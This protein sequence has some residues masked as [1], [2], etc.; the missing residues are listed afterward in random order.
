MQAQ[1]HAF[2]SV[3][4]I[5]LKY[6]F[7]LIYLL[8][9][10]LPI[11]IINLF[12]YQRNAESIRLREEIN[13]RKSLERASAELIGMIDEGVALS[14]AL[15]NDDSLYEAL[16]R[17]YASPVDYYAEYDSF[18][19]TKLD[20]FLSANPNILEIRIYTDNDTMI[21]G[22]N[23]NVIGSGSS[24]LPWLEQ[25]RQSD[26]NF[27]L[28]AYEGTG[29][30]RPGQRISV[31]SKMRTFASYRKYERY[32]CIDLNV[33]KI[34]AVLNRETESVQLG[35]LDNGNRIVAASA[36]MNRQGAQV[37]ITPASYAG[38]NGYVME[39]AIG[40]NHYVQGWK[41][42]GVA[43]TQRIAGLLDSARRSILW[44]AGLCTVIPT[45]LIFIILRSY[46]YRVKKLSRHMKKVRYE[47]FD[48]LNIPEGRD[49]VGDLIRTF[50][51]MTAKIASLINDVYKLEIRQKSLELERVRAELSMLHGQM[52]PHFLFNTLNA[53]L[54]VC[55]KNGYSDVSEIVQNLS[56]LMKQLL[57]R[58]DGF[59]SLEEELRF[60][61]MYLRI[62]KF[63]FGDL[64]AFELDIDPQTLPLRI[65]RMSIQPLVENACKHGLQAKKDNRSITI[66][67]KR[68]ERS[69]EI[70]VIDNGIGMERKELA[71]LMT[72]VRSDRDT[73]GHIGIRNVY[74]RLELYYRGHVRFVMHSEP[75]KGTKAGFRIPLTRLDG[76]LR[77]GEA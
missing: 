25:I 60:T 65:P 48:P 59:V 49:E 73:D 55:T 35:F 31:I 19:R 8:C 24:E 7:M 11:M 68:T 41:L 20:R 66:S 71:K 72:D 6:K 45:L 4:D 67:S 32:L 2:P 13:L 47:R 14:H 1:P 46:H 17:T 74:R 27:I 75:G 26:E 18:L 56:Q 33:N 43:D 16:D 54:F 15:A 44:L 42:V 64:F 12:F 62:E 63:R 21:S 5:P 76:D 38:S 69:L 30:F 61:S 9:V 77:D 36:G 70:T 23:Y 3:N 50:N 51:T 40:N 37:K 28:T 10:L 34:N 22:A 29:A 39:H 52:N 53:L 58:A 57:G